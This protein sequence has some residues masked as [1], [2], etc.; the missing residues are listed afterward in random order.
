MRK[1]LLVLLCLISVQAYALTPLPVDKAFEF[2]AITQQNTIV[3]QWNI[4]PTYQLYR[5]RIHINV[6]A[7]SEL[8]LGKVELPQGIEHDDSILGHYEVYQDALKITVPLENTQP[9]ESTLLVEYQGCS[10]DGFCYPPETRAITLQISQFGTQIV[11][12]APYQPNQTPVPKT[13]SLS[14]ETILLSLLTFFGLGILLAFTPC[15]LPMIPILSSIIVGRNSSKGRAFSLSITYVFGMAL[16]YAAAGLSAGYFGGS[17]QVALQQSWVLIVFA[18]VFVV[19]ALSMFGFYDLQL[20]T[21]WHNALSKLHQKRPTGTYVS[22]FIM[23][24]LSILI[25]S[26][27]IS[28]PLV[29]A[30]AYISKTGHTTLGGLALFSMG[31]GIGLPLL[32]LGTLGGKLLPKAGEWMNVVKTFFGVLLLMTS[33]WILYRI[34][35]PAVCMV[36][37]GLIAI[38]SSIYWGVFKYKKQIFLWAFLLVG[39]V[40]FCA[41]VVGHQ[42]PFNPFEKANA[43]SLQFTRIKTT[44]DLERALQANRGH[45]VMLDFYADWCSSCIVMKYTVFNQPDVQ[46]AL[47]NVVLLQADVTAND[48]NDKALE[49]ALGVF[50]PPTIIFFDENGKEITD[51]RIVGDVTKSKFEKRLDMF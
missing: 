32:I 6:L 22:A 35:S 49:K 42:N 9:S 27:C 29:A 15:V 37:W 4:A 13:S 48:A 36:L 25:A 39:V 46:A 31:L 5:E 38:I 50:A 1:I 2:T 7:P 19:L 51:A 47:N 16:A 3:L 18:L 26:P 8:T 12:I 43:T 24:A 11:D 30:L 10:V 20:P 14:V 21:R 45:Y 28:A 33:V 23:G 34:L 40:Y 41:G 17:L 44:A